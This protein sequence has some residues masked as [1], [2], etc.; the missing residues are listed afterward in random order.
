MNKVIITVLV[1]LSTLVIA[2]PE[3]TEEPIEIR[4]YT[5]II[6]ERTGIG[7]YTGDAEVR[8]GSL[9]LSAESIKVITAGN[10]V[11]KVVAEGTKE[12]PAKYSQSQQNQP[13][14]IEAIAQLIIYD[15]ANGLVFLKGGARLV[16][17]FESFSG[18]TMDYDIVNEKVI[19]KG[20]EDG[21]TRVKFKIKM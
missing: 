16:Q 3:D 4:A 20:S 5:V 2:L 6:D 7:E 10:E 19:V 17:G 1:L 11:L 12:K 9:F 18:E 13:R 14:F 15:V 21:T 8:Q